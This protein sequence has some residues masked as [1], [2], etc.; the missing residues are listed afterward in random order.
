[1]NYERLVRRIRQDPR[2]FAEDSV[3]IDRVLLKAKSKML[4][5][6]R[7]KPEPVGPYSGL[8]RAELRASRTCEPDWY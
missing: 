1:M 2:L 7:R 4:A 3:K 6:R 5:H 8:T